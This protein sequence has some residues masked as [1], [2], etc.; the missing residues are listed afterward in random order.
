VMLGQISLSLYEPSKS[1]VELLN[2]E[3]GL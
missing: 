3:L 1:A 2:A